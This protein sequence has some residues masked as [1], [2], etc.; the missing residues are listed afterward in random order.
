MESSV[1]NPAE[2]NI[3]IAVEKA[4]D[5]KL[6]PPSFQPAADVN[7]ASGDISCTA[8]KTEANSE[9]VSEDKNDEEK[10]K[11]C[12]IATDAKSPKVF[13][14]VD[15]PNVG[16]SPEV[17]PSPKE[18]PP[19]PTTTTPVEQPPAQPPAQPLPPAPLEP[20]QPVPGDIKGTGA[21][22]KMDTDPPTS[23]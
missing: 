15:M 10:K 8:E 3:D 19:P 14:E 16:K 20:L 22:E 1:D 23:K 6:V 5:D 4:P 11:E 9:P 17:I 7:T 13:K 12:A 2:T 21:P 18:P